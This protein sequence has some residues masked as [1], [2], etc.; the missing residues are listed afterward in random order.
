MN[1]RLTSAS[2]PAMTID[3]MLDKLATLTD[4]PLGTVVHLGAGNG[5]EIGRASCRERVSL[6]V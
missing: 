5:M 4:R 1:D 3:T 6:N 2:P